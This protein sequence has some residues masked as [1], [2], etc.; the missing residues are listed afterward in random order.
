MADGKPPSGIDATL[1]FDPDGAT[2]GLPPISGRPHPRQRQ[3]PTRFGRYE[4][5]AHLGSGGMGSVYLAYDTQLDRLVALKVPHNESDDDP[6]IVQRFRAEAQA[7]AGLIH[8]NLCTVHDVGE[9]DGVPYLTMAYVRGR[10][11]TDLL[12]NGEPMLQ[13]HAA[14]IVQQ[15]AAAMDVAHRANIIHRDLKPA[16]ILLGEQGAP[17]VMDFGVAR[18]DTMWRRRLTHQGTSLGTPGYM[19]PEALRGEANVVGPPSDI[20]SLGVSLYQLITA[21]LPFAGSPVETVRQILRGDRPTPPE[22]LRPDID[23]MLAAICA[24][25]MAQRIEDRYRTMGEFAEAL[26]EFLRGRSRKF[27]IGDEP[28]PGVELTQAEVLSRAGQQLFLLGRW[29]VAHDVISTAANLPALD[30]QSAIRQRNRLVHLCK[31]MDRWTEGLGHSEWCFSRLGAADPPELQARVTLNRGSTFY[32]LGRRAEAGEMF[33][34]SK[35]HAANC[36]TKQGA[37]LRAA[38]CN[39]LGIFY[40]YGDQLTRAEAALAEG[41]AET[42]TDPLV[43]AYLETNLGLV[44][45]TRSLVDP[46]QLEAAT[47]T[48][49]DVVQRFSAGGHL[50]GLSYALSNRGVCDLAAG[51]FAEARAAFEETIRLGERLGEKW[52]VY[53]ANANLALL[54]LARPGG[55]ASVAFRLASDS[56]ARAIAVQDPK[57]VADASLVAARAVIRGAAA[58]PGA[59]DL[60]LADAAETFARLG[61]KLGEALACLGRMELGGGEKFAQRADAILASTELSA[62]PR[63]FVAPPWHMLLLMELF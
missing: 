24:R 23:P 46:A 38:A 18:R 52:T 34:T 61:Q 26:L 17:V 41:L 15:V 12:I 43:A 53:G 56:I 44:Q 28:L 4:V 36:R 49:T 14:L 7:A 6:E 22:Q 19:A 63:Q 47:V 51:R 25:A 37:L 29:E 33:R 54:E 30:T 21:K 39:D 58:P 55:D 5:R 10:P 8:P 35:R 48:L 40:H 31:S 45:L 2:L 27:Q 59:A 9:I 62:L 60:L 16:N 20:Y 1:R 57:G 3:V 32:D 50:Q 42:D 13:E 11:L